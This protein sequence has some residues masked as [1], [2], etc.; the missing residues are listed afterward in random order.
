MTP[1]SSRGLVLCGDPV[2]RNHSLHALLTCDT[3]LPVAQMIG[4]LAVPWWIARE[5]GA[6][7]LALYGLVLGLATLVALPLL[8]PLSE[9]HAKRPQMVL[10][11]VLMSLAALAFAVQAGFANYR[12]WHLMV[13]GCVA[14]LADTLVSPTS[15]AVAAELVNPAQLPALLQRRKT[16]Q[17]FGRLVGPVASGSALALAG[18]AASLWLQCAMFALVAMAALRMP[19]SVPVRTRLGN[20]N[21][22]GNGFARWWAD[23]AAGARAKWAVPIERGWTAVN[24]GVWIFIAPAVGMLVPLKVRYGL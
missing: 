23:L 14:V 19:S 6:S 15:A 1:P 4:H 20:G 9:R 13:V 2:P 17:S 21:G 16:A 12:L 18:V 24:F 8:A 3:L 22:N 11:L 10:G 7:D 5:G